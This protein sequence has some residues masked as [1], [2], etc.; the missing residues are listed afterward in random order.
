MDLSVLTMADKTAWSQALANAGRHDIYHEAWYHQLAETS[1]E[2]RA[3]LVV[4]T[5]RGSTVVLPLLFRAIGSELCQGVEGLEDAT[6]VYG[7][8]GPVGPA[9]EA[10]PIVIAEL[11]EGLRSYLRE[12]G[13]V[14]LFSRLHPIFDQSPLIGDASDV[15]EAGATV[16]VDL[17]RT[18]EQQWS[19]TRSGHRNGINRLRRA[20]FKCERR[21][22][23]D[24]SVFLTIYEATMQRLAATSY[25]L[26]PRSHYEALLD[27]QRGAMELFIVAD[28]AGIPAAVGLFSMRC[29]IAQYHLSG[30]TL[31]HRKY[32]PTTLLID[33]ARRW[34]T[35]RGATRLHLGGG[36]GG[37][38]D[39]LFDFKAGFGTGRH[40]FKVWKWI[41]R[42]SIYRELE[43]IRH[44]REPLPAPSFFPIYRS[45]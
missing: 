5:H 9:G 13:T 27:P 21:T 8:P 7:Y 22:I 20:G 31:E 35:E 37:A 10:D 4:A 15:V 3:E 34:A 44:T 45:P 16:S 6:S 38:R 39:S 36:L 1:G 40:V 11:A 17:S 28:A 43:A 2:G 23:D 24:I 33:E 14:A 19:D 12:R 26:F 18:T 25:Y 32:A 42:P 30:A 29:G 41:L